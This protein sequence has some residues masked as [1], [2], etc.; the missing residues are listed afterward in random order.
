M[1][2]DYLLFIL[3]SYLKAYLNKLLVRHYILHT[4]TKLLHFR[5]FKY[6]IQHKCTYLQYNL[7]YLRS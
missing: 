1:L 5:L 2:E 7:N 3:Y 4:Y 6:L